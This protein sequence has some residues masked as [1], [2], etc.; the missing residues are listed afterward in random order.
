M[1]PV[2]NTDGILQVQKAVNS[3]STSSSS[4]QCIFIYPGTYSEQVHIAAR[5]AKLTIY[6][7]T[8]DTSSYTSNVVTIT[9]SSC[10]ACGAANDEA[11]GK[12]S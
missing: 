2:I 11:T 4:P 12:L 10:L 1:T 5:N 9:H 3:L 7:Y 6:G 8:T